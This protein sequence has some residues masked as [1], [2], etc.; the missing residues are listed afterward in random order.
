MHRLH[1]ARGP[2]GLCR[3]GATRPGQPR[4]CFTLS[5]PGPTFSTARRIFSGFVSSVRAQKSSA[6]GFISIA[7]GS[8]G[9]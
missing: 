5:S 7:V 6:S 8:G 9:T 4:S 1:A 2:H 3:S